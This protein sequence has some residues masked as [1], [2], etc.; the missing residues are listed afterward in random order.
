[1]AEDVI[2]QLD[3]LSKRYGQT[4]TAD[5]LSLAVNRREFFTFL[6]PSGSGNR[7]SCA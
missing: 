5:G 4:V 2:L 1:M 6:G 7:R 3:R